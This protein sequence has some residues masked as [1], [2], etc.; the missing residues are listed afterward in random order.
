[1]AQAKPFTS[2]TLSPKAIRVLVVDDHSLVC[3]GLGDMVSSY[4]SLQL[5]GEAQNGEMACAM[6]EQLQPAVILMDVHMPRMNGI[7]AT[8]RIKTTLPDTVI[9]G[10]SADPSVEVAQ[11]MKAAGAAANLTKGT[12][13]DDICRAIHSALIR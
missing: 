11:Q 4:E 13:P 3:A 1:M 2:P 5:V 7:E 8:R 9:I 12:H 10:L 6:A